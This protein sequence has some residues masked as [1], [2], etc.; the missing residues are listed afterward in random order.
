MSIIPL[1]MGTGTVP[2]P[3]QANECSSLTG[4]TMLYDNW[5]SS[6]GGTQTNYINN[7]EGG[8]KLIGPEWSWL[9]TGDVSITGDV[10]GP[11]PYSV[12][13][14]N[15]INF[16]F[17]TFQ[18]DDCMGPKADDPRGNNICVRDSFLADPT[19]CCIQ[20]T[21]CNSTSDCFVGN[22]TCAPEYRDL[23]GGP[24]EQLMIDFCSGNGPSNLYTNTANYSGANA[25]MNE[26]D[27]EG[28]CYTYMINKMFFSGEDKCVS[29][30]PQGTE[31]S[32]CNYEYDLPYDPEGYF[33]AQLMMQAVFSK[34]TETYDLGAP[35]SSSSHS[36]F[37]DTMFNDLCCSHVGL[38]DIALEDQCSS[39]S[40]QQLNGNQLL[41]QWCGCHLTQNYYDDYSVNYDIPKE[42]TPMCSKYGVLGSMSLTGG[43]QLCDDNVCIIDDIT[44]NLINVSAS[45]LQFNQL[46]S[47][48]T[49]ANCSCIISNN[50]VDIANSTIGGKLIPVDEG[51]GNLSCNVSNTGA[52]PSNIVTDCQG[53]NGLGPINEKLKK[54]NETDN[55]ISI[56]I[57]IMIGV[58]IILCVALIFYIIYKS[59]GR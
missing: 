19:Q 47:G 34:F 3:I 31:L 37:E 46:C 22:T 20:N 44:L 24:C 40:L 25:W 38:C 55:K 14:V 30:V 7:F 53:D 51:C 4:A 32:A 26:W 1:C 5:F 54:M 59:M 43:L 36:T 21:S 9:G 57:N 49:D 42:C 48:C 23:Y 13:G 29:S 41:S 45:T 16:P 10:A 35:S 8:C 12:N 28:T 50:D 18:Y 52:G 2:V 33:V 27:S 56:G 58:I 15:N 17:H 11:G 39:V 6:T